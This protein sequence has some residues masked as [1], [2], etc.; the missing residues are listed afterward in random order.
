MKNTFRRKAISIFLAILIGISGMIPAM[1]AF[2]GD[3]VENYY[4]LEIFD[5]ETDTM[6]PT[7]NEDGSEYNIYMYEG[8]TKQ[9]TYK[10]INTVA[11]DSSYIKWNSENP[12]LVDTDQTGKVKAFD[13]SKGA[14]IHYWIDN[15]VK[16]IPILG[17]ALGPLLEKVFFN[18]Y[19]D[20]DTMDTQAIVDLLIKALG[21]ES[22]IADYIEAYQGQLVD[23]L[24]YYLDH[25]NSNIVC[26]LYAAD[27]TLLAEDKIHITVLKNEEWYAAFLP[28]GTHITNK[29]QINTTQAVGNEVQIY[30]ITTPQRLKFGT[31]Y[32]VKSSS[33]FTQG[34]SV[35]TVNDSGLVKFKNPGKATI[36]VSPDSEQVIAQLM[37]F[38]NYFYELNASGSINSDKMAQILIDYIGLDINREALRAILDTVLAIID[39]AQGAT[40]PAQL[41]ATAA[42]ILANV[43]LQMVYNDSITFN[44]VEAQPIT[45]FSLAGNTTVKE[46][47]QIQLEVVDVQPEMGD[48]SD[49]TWKSSKPEVASVDEKTGVITGL[50]AGGSYGEL[51]S[52][53]CE[54]I[55]TSAANGVERRATITV[56]GKAGSSYIS[57]VQIIGDS[58]VELNA[59]ADYSYTVFPKRVAESDKLFVEWGIQTGEDEEGNPQYIWATAD[60]PAVGEH[61]TLDASGH[62]TSTSGGSTIIALKA[63]TGISLSS[64]N[65]YEIS[66]KIVT[67]EVSTGVPVDEVKI[68]ATGTTSNGKLNRNETKTINGKEY[69]FVTI[70]KGAMEGYY[71]NG[72]KLSAEIFPADATNRNIQWKTDNSYYKVTPSEDTHSVEIIQKANH[73]QAD[74]FNVWA[75]GDDGKIKSNVITVCITKKYVESNTIEPAVIEVVNSKTAT[76]SHSVTYEKNAA[77]GDPCYNC[78]WFSSDESIF[79]VENT[80]NDKNDAVL[81]G[82]DVGEAILYSYTADG[83]KEAQAKVIVRPNKD[84]LRKIVNM[85]D[86]AVVE[87]TAANKTLYKQYLGHLDLAYSVLYDHDMASQDTCDTYADNLL[88]AFYKLGGYITI[89]GIKIKGTKGADLKSKYVS[90]KVGTVADYRKYSYD[91]DYELLP[92]E[93]MYNEVKFKSSSPSTV[94][95]D[96]STGVCRP[97]KDEACGAVI[98]CTVTDYLGNEESD[99]VYIAFART[100]ATGVKLNTTEITNAPVDTTQQLTAT[101]LPTNTLGKST[102]SVQNVVWSSSDDSIATVDGDGLVTFHAGGDCIIR[103]TTVDGGYTAECKVN[104]ITNYSRLQNLIQQY[105]DLRLIEIDY[106]PDTW[107]AYTDAMTEAQ[108]MIDRGGYSQYAV[109]DMYD[110]LENAYKSLKKYNYIQKVELYLDGEETKEFYQY[111]ASLFKEGFSYKNAVLDLNVRLYPNNASYKDVVWTSSTSNIS[112]T[113]DGKCTPTINKPCYGMITCTVSDHYGN[114]YSDSVWVS[115]SYTPVTELTLSDTNINGK[116]GDTH[117]LT[118]TVK[119]TGLPGSDLGS[120]SIKDYYWE[121]DDE[122][123][124][125]ISNDADSKGVVTFVNAGTTKV[126][127]VSYDGG[128]SAECIVSTEGDRSKLKEYL[129]EYKDIDVTQYNYDYAQTFKKAY[130]TAENALTDLSLSQQDIDDAAN[131]LNAAAKL[132]LQNPYIKAQSINLSYETYKDPVIG[133]KKK[134]KDGTVSDNNALSINVSSGYE[135]NNTR[136]SVVLTA[137]LQP[138]NAMYKSIEWKVLQSEKMKAEPNGSQITLTPSGSS[139]EA[140]WAQ[141]SYIVTDHYG[142]TV[143]RTVF[144][145]MADK[146]CTGISISPNEMNMYA[147]DSPYTAHATLSGNPDVKRIFWSSSDPSVATVSDSGIITPIN[148]GTVDII[149]K[150][151]DGGYTATLKLN[152]ATDFSILAEKVVACEKLIA[153]AQGNYMY[154]DESLE[155]LSAAVLESKTI[156]DKADATQLE[157]NS[158]LDTLN[159]AYDALVKYEPVKG[160][161]IQADSDQEN[162]TQPNE[163]F[164]RYTGTFLTN[165]TVQLVADLQPANAITT[166][167]TWESS[168]PNIT[169]DQFGL[170][171]NTKAA[172]DVALITCTVENVYGESYTNSAYVSFVTYP[173]KAVTFNDEMIFGAPQ[174]VKPLSFSLNQDSTLVS[175]TIIKKCIYKSSNENVA[176]IDE[177]GNVT[178]KTQGTAVITVTALDGGFTGSITAYTTWDT[179]ALQEAITKAEAIE[180]TDY[181]YTQGTAFKAA[182]DKAVEVYAN[183]FATQDEIDT[184]CANLLEAITNLEGNEFVLP[185]PVIM[186]GSKQVAEGAAFEIND[187]S[188][189]TFTYQMNEGAMI[190]SATLSLVDTQG[191]TAGGSADSLVVTKTAED[192]VSTTIKLTVVDDYDREYEYSY[193]VN[194]VN[195]IVAATD[196][197]ITI[198]GDV[199]TGSYVSSGHK[200]LYTD[201]KPLQLG[202][203]LTPSNAT[204]PQSVVWSIEN[205]S[206]AGIMEISDA[207]VLSLTSTGKA[208]KSNTA[209]I[210]CTI[211]NAD[212]SVIE[213]TINVIISR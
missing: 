37:K 202:Y 12:V 208:F 111:D 105:T 103:C 156:L 99:S 49:I 192:A 18:E 39:A 26:Q 61:G 121:S 81:T 204:E 90:V 191:L 65:F 1:S 10:L 172:S 8:D 4:T 69:Q 126:R 182:Y 165:K 78:N 194:I 77:V 44:V 97:V 113:S 40:N 52:Q 211:T 91:F 132:M 123:I 174:E 157:V 163:G 120:A 187:K 183:V 56:T 72:I 2:A 25:I 193:N 162:V 27:G 79:T 130:T 60:E 209:D 13:A 34:K 29:S 11:P 176:T 168:N 173:V 108:A 51:S 213:K 62:F 185:N 73:E 82:H 177:N 83:A 200:L 64:D 41:V 93:S 128:V 24:R 89:G 180:Y 98:T 57:D 186:A 59:S 23:S 17:K 43:I 112:V 137:G 48:K 92:K 70:H 153:E 31:V 20:L 133:G 46:G 134:V 94:F 152:I 181:A 129:D 150:S 179:T 58:R 96:E 155:V 80:Y 148:N 76:A 144:V 53:T 135:S 201:F 9:F 6:V 22:W 136:N 50:D 7:E 198:N 125:T 71:N 33:I 143:S 115:Y 207:G 32:T 54:I 28:N 147:T 178:F 5:A 21:S 66:S 75:V 151:L 88:R 145:S 169:V 188:Q 100:K 16:T 116:V 149:V 68:T 42:E 210:K 117:Q 45:S 74:S 146:T 142:L 36:Q 203:V 212:G 159:A 127:A 195:Q 102:A 197:D 110:K 3:G 160:V 67:K 19:V 154:T 38:I 166:N 141:V 55:A 158:Y 184:A 104:V 199:Y 189:V 101:V 107:K 35:A 139:S 85:C 95:V 138:A 175:S 14:V 196:F 206:R 122:N 118:C 47:T 171:T 63:K 106:Y 109:N 131:A 190:K 30:A 86:S 167:V 87:R 161:T 15:E 114:S 140:G 124:A 170:V 164:I 205:P 84:Y 119:P